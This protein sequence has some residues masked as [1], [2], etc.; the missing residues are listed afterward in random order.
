MTGGGNSDAR[1]DRHEERFR[2]VV[3]TAPAP[4]AMLGAYLP[5]DCAM[6]P[7]EIP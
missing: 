2:L 5:I 6:N 7:V 3:E 1:W 4:I